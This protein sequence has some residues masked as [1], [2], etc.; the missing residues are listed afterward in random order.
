MTRVLDPQRL[1]TGRVLAV[2]TALLTLG[3][4]LG[5]LLVADVA[6]PPFQSL[7]EGWASWVVGLRSPF[8]DGINA[9]LNLAGYRGVLVLDGLLALALLLRRRPQTAIFTAVAGVAVLV[10][11]QILKASIH[12]TRPENTIVLTDTGSFPSG[13]VATTTALLLVLA[14]LVGRTWV[15]VLAAAGIL[16][17][18]VSRTYVSAHWLTD[19]VGGVC[20]AAPVVL[21]LWLGYQNICIQENKDA[22][23]LLTWR[24]RA[25]RRRQ[26]AEHPESEPR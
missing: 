17:M 24:A 3:V 19:T 16:F 15:W 10:L 14:I 26:A 25:S 21:L 8:W 5:G 9:F 2:S 18:M 11:T 13:H 6:G 20:L 22:R 1:P 12:R 23:R 4:I 7:D